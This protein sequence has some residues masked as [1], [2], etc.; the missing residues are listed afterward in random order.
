MR[1]HS[2]RRHTSHTLVPCVSAMLAQPCTRVVLA[3][4]S[5]RRMPPRAARVKSKRCADWKSNERERQFST[6]WSN[7]L[8][9]TSKATADASADTA[10]ASSE[11]ASASFETRGIAP[12]T[13]SLRLEEAKQEEV[14]LV[15]VITRQSRLTELDGS[16]THASVRTSTPT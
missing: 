14:L 4:A 11:A 13:T 15:M 16:C 7:A 2:R 8:P 6:C 12:P 9:S 5:R 10:V 3:R 1:T